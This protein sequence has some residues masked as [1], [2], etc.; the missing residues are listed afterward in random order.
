MTLLNAVFLIPRHLP[1][2]GEGTRL[3]GCAWVYGPEE[4]KLNTCG[5][6]LL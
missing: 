6:V 1:L 3:S 4:T 2:P 5:H